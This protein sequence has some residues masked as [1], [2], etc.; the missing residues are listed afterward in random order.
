MLLLILLPLLT[1]STD[2]NTVFRKDC[3]IEAGAVCA[4][5]VDLQLST[6]N[7]GEV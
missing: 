7:R 2:T 6:G 1:S 5:V 3:F 4:P